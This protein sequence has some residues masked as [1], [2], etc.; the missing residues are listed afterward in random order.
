MLGRHPHR[1]RRHH[2]HH[3]RHRTIKKQKIHSRTQILLP[4]RMA[5]AVRVTIQ[6]LQRHHLQNDHTYA[7]V[8]LQ[9]DVTK[10]H[11]EKPSC[12]SNTEVRSNN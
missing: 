3:H 2:H 10:M 8:P 1:R 5:V 12:A 6:Q 9:V 4:S 7:N 11:K